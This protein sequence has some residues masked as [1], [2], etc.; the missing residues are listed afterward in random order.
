ME[1]LFTVRIRKRSEFNIKNKVLEN[2]DQKEI[3]VLTAKPEVWG[4]S[5]E[6]VIR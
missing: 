1:K 4:F 2:P 5:F 6:N 3:P